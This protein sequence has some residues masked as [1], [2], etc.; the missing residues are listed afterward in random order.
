[1]PWQSHNNSVT[2]SLIL[3]LGNDIFVVIEILGW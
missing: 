3:Y 1:L 2:L